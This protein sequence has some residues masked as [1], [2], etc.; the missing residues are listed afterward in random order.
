MANSSPAFQFYPADFVGD[1]NVMAMST[2]EAGAYIFLICAAWEEKPTGTLPDDDS[3]LARIA[4]L[5]LS[6]WKRIKANVMAAFVYDDELKRWKQKRLIRE[7]AHQ[8]ARRDQAKN[9][10]AK[11]W[12][13]GSNADGKRKQC[14]G[15]AS[16]MH[17]SY[18]FFKYCCYYYW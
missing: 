4:R 2:T 12:E 3:R 14:G 16:G 17:Y 10:S 5:R 8:E 11:R 13:S 15:N 6:D 9:A 7:A 1:P 18:T